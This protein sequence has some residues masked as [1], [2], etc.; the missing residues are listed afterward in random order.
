MQA[1]IIDDE[2]HCRE[3]LSIML[4]KYCPE[5][6]VL[7]Q[8]PGT[9]AALQA[10]GKFHPDLIFLD[11][12]M[13]GMNGFE[14][15]E[16]CREYDFEVIF[17]T[18]YNEYA[19]QAIRHSALDYLLKPVNKNELI[20]AVARAKETRQATA[21]AR[22][23]QLLE[24]IENSKSS[25]RIALPTIDGL[26]IVDIKDILYCESENNYTRFHLINEKTLFVS[27]TLKKV[28]ALLMNDKDFFR[29][30]HSFVINL[31]YIQRYFKGD[32][33]EISLSN[34]KNLPVS[35]TKKP[36]F[37]DRLTNL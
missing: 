5:V 2:K 3:G 30:H 11:I 4:S 31:R 36:A 18:A 12:E 15:L 28:E 19:I 22:I 24:L 13:P 8:C 1:L 20:L 16:N 6:E 25:E 23:T 7:A 27:K 34:G 14:M 33:G 32:G 21:P 17:T 35:R 37:L 29:I 26:I 10:I 9:K